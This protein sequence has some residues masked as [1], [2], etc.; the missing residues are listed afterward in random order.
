ML[1]D[2]GAEVLKVEPPAGGDPLRTWRVVKD[3]NSIWWEAQSRNKRS[4][5]IDLRHPEGQALARGLIAQSDVVIENF[6]P[7]QLEQWGLDY[8]Q[9]SQMQPGLIMLRISG[10]GQDGPYRDRPGFGV[11][12][13][14]MGGYATSRESRAVFQCGWGCRLEIRLRPCTA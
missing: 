2:F 7:G 8:A 14:A 9:L 6:R 4:V 10:Y 13:E 1:A 11:I 5:A 12:G 3:G